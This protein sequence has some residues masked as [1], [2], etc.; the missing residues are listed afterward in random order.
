M[1]ANCVVSLTALTPALA[2]IEN[3]ELRQQ[4]QGLTRWIEK[5]ISVLDPIQNLAHLIDQFTS[6]LNNSVNTVKSV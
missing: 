1:P 4:G 2:Q 6:P 5:R 3:A